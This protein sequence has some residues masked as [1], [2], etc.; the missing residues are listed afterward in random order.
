[1]MGN[2]SRQTLNVQIFILHV[3]NI[4]DLPNFNSYCFNETVA[5]VLVIKEHTRGGF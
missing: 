3:T 2:Q 5:L 1:M 4:L